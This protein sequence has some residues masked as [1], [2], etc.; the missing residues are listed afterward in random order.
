MNQDVSVWGTLSRVQR[1]HR[2]QRAK[3]LASG[4]LRVATLTLFSSHASP[5]AK[6][7]RASSFFTDW[8]G[9]RISS[10]HEQTLV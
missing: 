6:S 2:F 5:Q 9:T 4:T 1:L 3:N 10:L 7:N 8:F